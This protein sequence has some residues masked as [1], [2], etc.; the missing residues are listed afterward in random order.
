MN[1]IDQ[2]VGILPLNKPEIRANDNIACGPTVIKE[3]SPFFF[4]ELG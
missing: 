2:L 3:I 4:I 1:I